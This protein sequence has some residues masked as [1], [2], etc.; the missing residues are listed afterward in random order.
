MTKNPYANAVFAA[1]YIVF[2]VHVMTTISTYIQDGSGNK[3]LIP[4]TFLSLFVFSAVVMGFLFVLEPIGMYIDGKKHEAVTFF[5]K[6]VATF[7][8]FVLLFAGAVLLTL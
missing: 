4:M 1:L 6:T 3:I 5:L 2:I 8:C 7:G